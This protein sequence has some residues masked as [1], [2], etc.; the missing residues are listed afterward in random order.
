MLST[1]HMNMLHPNVK[2]DHC[3]FKGHKFF[4]CHH[5]Y[6]HFLSRPPLHMKKMLFCM[7]ISTWDTTLCV[8]YVKLTLLL[9][10][11]G[12]YTGCGD[13]NPSQLGLSHLP[14]ILS[15][16]LCYT[17][18]KQVYISG[19]LNIESCIACR[20]HAYGKQVATR[21]ARALDGMLEVCTCVM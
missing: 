12:I 20:M 7:D 8:L 2:P 5:F 14:K 1:L 18:V 6:I 15:I 11:T 9:H 13:N 17:K 19:G 4:H 10:I 16:A 3:K 21:E